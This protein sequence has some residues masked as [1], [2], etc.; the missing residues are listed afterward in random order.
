MLK[1]NIQNA[2]EQQE[3]NR[4]PWRARLQETGE[5]VGWN[6]VW[7]V[8]EGAVCLSWGR[9]PR[10]FLQSIF[11]WKQVKGKVKEVQLSFSLSL[12]LSGG[13]AS[14]RLREPSMRDPT[15]K[16]SPRQSPCQSVSQSLSKPSAPVHHPAKH[17]GRPPI[18][19]P[20]I[21][22]GADQPGVSSTYWCPS[23]PLQPFEALA[24]FDCASL[25]MKPAPILFFLFPSRSE[26]RSERCSRGSTKL[27]P[28]RMKGKKN[29]WNVLNI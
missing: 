1:E 24:L 16:Q 28:T 17:P 20:L 27:N 29:I 2:G 8:S 14:V 5:E 3:H 21:R 11:Q 23:P 19:S 22:R 26:G 18:R 10:Y 25:S 15:H 12:S 4:F 9:V 6:K 7:R 13:N